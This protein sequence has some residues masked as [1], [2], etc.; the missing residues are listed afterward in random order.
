MVK[1]FLDPG[2]GGND[3]GAADNGIKEK[4]I[5]LDICKRIEAGL[6]KYEDTTVITSRSSDVF[7]SLSERTQKANNANA[8]L[9]LSV[10]INAAANKAAKG[11]ESFVYT[12]VNSGTVAFQNVLHA[13][14]LRAMGTGIEDRGKKRANFHMVRESKMKAVLTENLFITN[15][16]EASKLKDAA[17]RQKVAEGHINGVVKFLG[18]KKKAGSAPAPD[19][20]KAGKLYKIQVGA[21]GEKSNAYGLEKDLERN[22]ISAFV[23]YQDGLYLVQ[24]GAYSE[25][26]LAEAAAARLQKLGYRP[27]IKYE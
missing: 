11:F 18:L 26:N 25:K 14:I 16:G 24:A 12:T 4:D 20:P 10:H 21:F 3:G 5:V 13:E 8:D 19:Q 1:I 6:K 9:L 2:H 17:F 7:L 22:G 15:S 23:D 27:Y